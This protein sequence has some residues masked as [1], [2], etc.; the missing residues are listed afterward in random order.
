MNTI[1]H[2]LQIK[3]ND[4]WTIVP[5]ATVFEALRM[6][7]EKDVGALLVMEH[8]QL[9]GVISERDYSRKIILHGKA[10]KDTLVHEV[11]TQELYPIHPDQTIQECMELMTIK[12]AR[13]VPV[14]EDNQVIGIVSIGDVVRDIMYQQR[15]QIKNLEQQVLYK[16]N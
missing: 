16:Q 13:Y 8:D 6:M 15:E 7:A 3:G 10:S 12:R 9:L 4:L 2:I 5:G 11:M 1:R 14:I